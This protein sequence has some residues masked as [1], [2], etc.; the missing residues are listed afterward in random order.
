VITF[1]TCEGRKSRITFNVFK[2]EPFKNILKLYCEKKEL[3][4]WQEYMIEFDGEKVSL[5]E[6]ANDLDLD[7]D[8]IFDVKKNSKA[9]ASL[10]VINS[11]KNNY[12]FDDDILVA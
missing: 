1:Q 9:G 8:E 3:G 11:N 5:E 7:G 10:D 12:Q 2:D 6:N 4:N